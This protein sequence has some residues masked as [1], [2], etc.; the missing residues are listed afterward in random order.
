MVGY[1]TNWGRP[2]PD[3]DSAFISAAVQWMRHLEEAFV[4]HVWAGYDRMDS[5]RPSVDTRDLERSITQLLDCMIRDEMSDDEPYYLQHGPCERETMKPPPAQPPTYD[6]AFVFRADPRIMWPLEAK[7]LTT[8]QSLSN[9]LKDIQKE[10][11]TC[12]YAPFSPSGA[13]L[14]YLLHGE[15][16]ETLSNISARLN[17]TLDPMTA[18][19][20]RPCAVSMHTR[21]VPLEKPYPAIFDCHHIILTFHGLRRSSKKTHPDTITS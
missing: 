10:F 12:R 7:V 11:L 5:Q 15:P 1:D 20:H 9:Y 16:E 18:F 4:R 19:A 21:S 3:V 6:L 2:A 8:S 13:M 17:C 14:G